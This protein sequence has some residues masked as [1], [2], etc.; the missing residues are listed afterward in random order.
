MKKNKLLVVY[1]ICGIS[2]DK[3]DQYLSHIETII[4]QDIEDLVVV[5]SA[6]KN[7]DLTIRLIRDRFKDYDNFRLYGWPRCTE[8]TTTGGEPL[9][10][11]ITFNQAVH[12][13]VK[14]FGEFEYYCYMDSGIKL[15]KEEQRSEVAE[16]ILSECIRSIE[17]NNYGMLNVK[18]DT[19][20]LEGRFLKSYEEYY[21]NYEGVDYIM[22]FGDCVNLHIAIWPHEW[23]KTYGR[24]LPDVFRRFTSE[25]VLPFMSAGLKKKIAILA[26]RQMVHVRMMDGPSGDFTKEP[27]NSVYSTWGVERNMEDLPHD[28]DAIEKYGIG[29][30]ELTH[31]IGGH[32]MHRESCYH[33]DY[34]PKYP[35]KLQEKC[36]QW[37]CLTKE[38]WDYNNPKGNPLKQPNES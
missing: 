24:I 21:R 30:E 32:V 25:S 14:D 20:F 22:P 13:A 17:E 19:D 26:D 28:T 7:T 6:Y 38:E 11:N 16:D 10:V 8:N 2:H 37:F 33:E 5:V 27:P 35:K 36:L 3:A 15:S 9:S 23:L 29:Y 31:D 34:I 4:H 18:T 1:N 12:W